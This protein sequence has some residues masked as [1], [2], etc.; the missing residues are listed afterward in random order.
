MSSDS[1]ARAIMDRIKQCAIEIYHRTSDS[2]IPACA[3]INAL[4]A[5]ARPSMFYILL[6]DT[7]LN[8]HHHM[9]HY[10]YNSSVCVC[11]CSKLIVRCTVVQMI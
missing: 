9:D 11:L 2:N 10:L 8:I 5:W 6:V 7:L 3:I 4:L 1:H